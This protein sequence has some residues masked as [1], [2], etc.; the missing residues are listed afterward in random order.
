MTPQSWIELKKLALKEAQA[1]AA[2]KGKTLPPDF[3][4]VVD[5]WRLPYY[6]QYRQEEI[7]SIKRDPDKVAQ[8]AQI[9]KYIDDEEKEKE[10]RA[11]NA[12]KVREA[13]DTANLEDHARRKVEHER[14]EAE[15]IAENLAH[16]QADQAALGSKKRK[17][18]ELQQVSKES[19]PKSPKIE[20]QQPVS[21][22]RSWLPRVSS[23][24]NS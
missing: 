8:W 4:P 9:Q 1:E 14:K 11:R 5:L 17:D 20:G 10:D 13:R 19:T 15:R 3:A 18:R 23:P 16:R 21:D 7:E 2:K 6:R 24:D 22:D 12:E